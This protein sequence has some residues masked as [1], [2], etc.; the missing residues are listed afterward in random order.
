M[1][2][3]LVR[4]YPCFSSYAHHARLAYPDYK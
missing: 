1:F 3:H 2:Q 4:C